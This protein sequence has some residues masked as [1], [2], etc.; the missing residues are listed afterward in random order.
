MEH[1]EILIRLGTKE[2]LP[3]VHKLVYELAVYEKA[4]EELVAT[5][6]DYHR[7]FEAGIFE[8]LVAEAGGD[9]IGMA[10][11]YMTYST[12]KGRMLYLEDFVVQEPHRRRGI[13]RQLFEAF[14]NRAREKECRLAKWQVLDWNEPALDFYRKFDAAI[15]TNWWNG[16]IFFELC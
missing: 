3:D 5:V 16:K 14:L 6:E 12:W 7:D 13:G 10:L 9:I 11:Y 15:E 1:S 2:D 8:T 4:P